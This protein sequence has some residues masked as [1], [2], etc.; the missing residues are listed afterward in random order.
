MNRQI[1]EKDKKDRIVLVI[2]DIN[3]ENIKLLIISGTSSFIILIG[4]ILLMYLY[5]CRKDNRLNKDLF[6]GKD[7]LDIYYYII[8]LHI[9]FQNKN[10]ASLPNVYSNKK[11]NNI[12]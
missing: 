7:K 1:I 8:I 10:Q 2:M 4:R 3:I 12:Q 11:D 5:C 6:E 9:E